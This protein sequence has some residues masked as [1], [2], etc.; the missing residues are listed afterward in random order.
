MSHTAGPWR[1]GTACGS[2]VSDH[3]IDGGVP[4]SDAL[5]YY[6]GHLIAESVSG[7]NVPVII[8]APEMLDWIKTLEND[9]GKIP[10]WLWKQR[11]ALIAKAE[12]VIR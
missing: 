11:A 8:A 3:P 7:C 2:V 4:G 6:G 10:E 12:G 1:A 5:E 9:D